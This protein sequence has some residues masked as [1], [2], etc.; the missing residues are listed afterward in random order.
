MCHETSIIQEMSAVTRL[1]TCVMS[2]TVIRQEG[3]GS[4]RPS[5]GRQLLM[6]ELNIRAGLHP[7]SLPERSSCHTH[8]TT[9][10]LQGHD[11]CPN[12]EPPCWCFQPLGAQTLPDPILLLYS[13]SLASPPTSLHV[14]SDPKNNLSCPL[15][16]L[17]ANPNTGALF[18]P[19]NLTI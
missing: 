13:F 4:E 16:N 18:G 2:F 19:Q 6:T 15:C 5:L 1:W 12:Q 7:H 9:C 3:T 8:T 14:F 10:P 17:L 11:Y